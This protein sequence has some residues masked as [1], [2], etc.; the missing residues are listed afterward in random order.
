MHDHEI[1]VV[2]SELL[3][4]VV[5]A[6]LH[7]RFVFATPQLCAYPDIGAI[8]SSIFQTLLDSWSQGSLVIVCRCAVDVAVANL[9]RIRNG[10][11]GVLIRRQFPRNKTLV[12]EVNSDIGVV[13][14]SFEKV[15]PRLIAWWE[16]FRRLR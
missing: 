1:N 9:D 11:G 10:Q 8:Q 13:P 16:G 4:I 5:H 7:L 15:H 3:E 12:E 14:L 2:Q 6:R